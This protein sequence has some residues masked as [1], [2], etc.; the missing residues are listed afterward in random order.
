MQKSALFLMVSFLLINLSSQRLFAQK[1]SVLIDDLLE[2]IQKQ[3]VKGQGEFLKG[4]FPSYISQSEKFKDVHPDNS[5]FFTGLINYTL[6][7]LKPSLN[8]SRQKIIDSIISIS[9][10]AFPHFKNQKGRN[11][12]NFWRTDTTVVYPYAGWLFDKSITLPDDMDDTVLSLMVQR[13]DDSIAKHVHD[14]MQSFTN[15]DTAT[16]R[17]VIPQF[18]DIHAYSTWFGKKFPVVFDVSVLSNVLTFVQSYN[19]KWSAADSA[20]LELILKTIE[21]DY[22]LTKPVYVSPYYP[23]PSLILYH[24]S[25]LMKNK[26]ITALENHKVKLIADAATI[27]Q[28]SENLMERIICANAILNWGY[29]PPQLNIP[30]INE[31]EPLIEK[32]DFSFFLGNIPSYFPSVLKKIA[33]EKKLGMFYHYC[34]AYY[35]TLLLEYLILKN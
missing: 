1:D 20:S 12:Y 35:D 22:H 3:Q 19:M 26:T 7:K 25:R 15:S 14:L 24:L 8:V 13:A 5:I 10:T 33:T 30:D 21:N 4:S 18:E 34:P 11:T 32:N 6:L 16:L 17:N 2:R 9:L 31:I 23:K 27:M 28:Q 29:L